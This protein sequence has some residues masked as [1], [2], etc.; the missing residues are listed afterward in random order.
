MDRFDVLI[1]IVYDVVGPFLG[2]L[3]VC[4][5]QGEGLILPLGFYVKPMGFLC[6][7]GCDPEFFEVMMEVGPKDWVS[8]RVY[9]LDNW[10]YAKVHHSRMVVFWAEVCS[11]GLR[12][13]GCSCWSI[14]LQYFHSL[15]FWRDVKVSPTYW[16]LHR[17]QV[18]R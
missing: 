3:G 8:C 17:R 9:A 1:P 2:R 18:M 11:T 5:H 14:Q 12:L 4:A 15:F 16:R 6:V 7:E 13:G 10:Y